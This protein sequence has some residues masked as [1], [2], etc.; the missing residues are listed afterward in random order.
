LVSIGLINVVGSL[1][2]RQVTC[3]I[4]LNAGREVAV[5]STKSY[6]AQVCAGALLAVWFAQQDKDQDRAAALRFQLIQ[7]LQALGGIFQKLLGI[8]INRVVEKLNAS[9]HCFI[10]G[11]GLAHSVA[12]EGALK[13]KEIAY[14]HAEGF[15]GGA[16]KHGPFALIESGT[17]IILLILE[18]QNRDRMIDALE[19]VKCRGAWTCVITNVFDQQIASHL[20]SLADQVIQ[21]PPETAK[22]TLLAPLTCIVPLQRIALDLALVRGLDPDKPRCLAKVVTVDG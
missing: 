12:L 6:V 22:Y 19:Q 7:G 13:I 8:S 17:P 21:L 4:H 15:A 5:A 10:L 11:R 1:I 3:G 9:E 14:L 20:D 16:L 2:A 18:D